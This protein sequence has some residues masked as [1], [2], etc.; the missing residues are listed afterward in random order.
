M[1]CLDID[2]VKAELYLIP[3]TIYQRFDWDVWQVDTIRDTDVSR[4]YVIG[5]T[6][7]VSSRNL[8]KVEVEG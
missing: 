7:P 4:E 3:A 2:L 5:A 1:P 8:V 6:E